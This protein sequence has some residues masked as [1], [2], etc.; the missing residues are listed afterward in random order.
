[1]K[2]M[3]TLPTQRAWLKL[4]SQS[5]GVTFTY[6]MILASYPSV[7]PDRMIIRFVKKHGNLSRDITPT[8]TSD[9]VKQVAKQYPSQHIA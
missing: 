7:K 1:M 2:R 9:L 5:S 8:Q 3:S 6:L 4:P